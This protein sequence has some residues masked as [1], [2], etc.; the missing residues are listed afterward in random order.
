VEQLPDVRRLFRIDLKEGRLFWRDV[1]RYH[2]SRNGQEAGC[3]QRSRRKSYWMVGIDGKL[4]LRG[5]L[6][7]LAVH[8]RW[9]TP[10]LDHINGN[11]LDDRLENLRECTQLQNAW[12]HKGRRKKSDLPMG[13]RATPHGKFA[14]RIAFKG[15]MLHLGH[16]ESAAQAAAIYNAKR[17][18]LYR[19]FA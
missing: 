11:S 19:E 2:A 8:G 12:N 16:F 14:A 7:F 15:T 6:I 4:Y 17:K 3:P 5:R 18:E 1:S 10:C 13:V 9:P